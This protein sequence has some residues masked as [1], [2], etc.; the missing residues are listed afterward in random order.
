MK[1]S[2][3]SPVYEFLKLSPEERAERLESAAEAAASLYEPGG[4]LRDFDALDDVLEY[5]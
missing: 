4:L 5:D 1:T 2:K 3:L